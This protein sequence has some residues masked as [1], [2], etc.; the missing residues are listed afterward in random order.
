MTEKHN[1]VRD[2]TV[3]ARRIAV[4]ASS[5]P[6]VY[7][8]EADLLHVTAEG[9][10]PWDVRHHVV[11]GEYLFCHLNAE[12]VLLRFELIYPRNLWRVAPATPVP[13]VSHGAALQFDPSA[14]SAARIAVL[15]LD[16][17]TDPARSY[18]HIRFG[19]RAERATWVA[20]SAQCSASI[21]DGRLTGFFVAIRPVD[22][23][24]AGM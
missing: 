8:D 21:A 17:L 9:S 10:A 15:K 7:D 20:L 18:A 6:L 1:M 2:I 24:Q 11:I 13:M 16:V 12:R 14:L 3:A 5:Q 19:A 22:V 4:A 23:P